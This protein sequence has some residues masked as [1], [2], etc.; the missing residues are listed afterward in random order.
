MSPAPWA[1]W[2]SSLSGTR[3]WGIFAQERNRVLRVK[4][5]SA[6]RHRRSRRPVEAGEWPAEA[7][8]GLTPQWSMR[9]IRIRKESGRAD[10]R[11][12]EANATETPK[13]ENTTHEGCTGR[14]VPLTI[15]WSF[16]GQVPATFLPWNHWEISAVNSHQNSALTG[17]RRAILFT[18]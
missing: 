7:L 17:C 8:G 5:Q 14:G 3:Q 9:N 12:C 2:A 4:S 13:G 11:E 10:R 1:L 16:W 15:F 18:S 6:Q